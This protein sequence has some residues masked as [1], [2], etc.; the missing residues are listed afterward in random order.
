[1]AGGFEVGAAFDRVEV[2]R[3]DISTKDEVKL[4]QITLAV[5]EDY[6]LVGGDFQLQPYDHIVVR[7]TPNFTRGRT[8]EV[9][10]RVKY[11]G[12]YVL[13]DNKTQLWEIIQMAGGLL[14]DADPY[15]RLFRTYNNRGNIGLDLREVK[16]N[17]GSLKSDPILMDGDVI[18]IVRL[19]NTV[20]IRETGT[21]MA[22]YVPGEY[23]ST[24]KLIVYQGKHSAAWYVRH[25]AGGFQ[26]LADKNSVT[27]TFPNNQSESTKR[28]FLGIRNYPEVEPGGVITMRIDEEKRE[29]IEKPKEKID[30]GN[31]LR[32]SLSTLTSVIS[33]IIL[34]DRL[35]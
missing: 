19:E 33:L 14:D 9:N 3:L 11:P 32:T 5:D 26:K 31:E 25:Y 21:R 13:E 24:Q 30:W 4:E 22:Q 12:S 17:K 15:A 20:T 6:N 29:R 23:S 18:N 34:V 35:K 8:V 7:M 16:S 1:M 28:R 10:G 2:F 27:V